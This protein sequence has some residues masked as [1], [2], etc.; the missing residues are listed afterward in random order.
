[1]GKKRKQL[2]HAEIWDDSA[3]VQSWDD[4]LAEYK[5]SDNSSLALRLLSQ[6]S[7]IIAFMRAANEWKI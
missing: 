2:S 5:V 7:F 1:M 4:A 6:N 3:L